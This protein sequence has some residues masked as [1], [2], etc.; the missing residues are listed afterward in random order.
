MSFRQRVI[1]LPPPNAPAPPLPQNESS[2]KPTQVRVK[3]NNGDRQKLC[4]ICAKLTLKP[5]KQHY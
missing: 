2:K 4:K 3:V 1:L 5:L